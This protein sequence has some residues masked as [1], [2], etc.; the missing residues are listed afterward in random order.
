MELDKF[1]KAFLMICAFTFGWFL[2]NIEKETNINVLHHGQTILNAG[3]RILKGG[4]SEETKQNLNTSISKL[5]LSTSVPNTEKGVGTS[6]KGNRNGSFSTEKPVAQ[7][8]KAA[9]RNSTPKLSNNKGYHNTSSTNT[10][11][12]RKERSAM[13]Q[14][15]SHL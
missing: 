6:F 4:T 7:K 3:I 1:W 14:G 12:V 5:R 9:I 10:S 11:I 15:R 2:C 13:D 8:I